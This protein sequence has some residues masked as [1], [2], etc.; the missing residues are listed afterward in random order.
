VIALSRKV[1]VWLAALAV[2]IGLGSSYLLDAGD[3][4]AEATAQH[5]EDAEHD[6]ARFARAQRRAV[7]ERQQRHAAL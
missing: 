5:V 6:E 2:A 3:D 4:G 7:L 1:M